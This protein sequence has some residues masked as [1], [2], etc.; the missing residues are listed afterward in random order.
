MG[1]IKD[2]GIGDLNLFVNGAV[3]RSHPNDNLFSIDTPSG[4]VPVAGLLYDAPNFG[5]V[6][7]GHTGTALYL[8]TRYDITSTG[9]KIGL[10]YNYGSK[11]W[12]AFTPASDDMWTSKL[13]AHGN[14]YEA[15]VIQEIK[16]KPISKV[17]QGLLQAG[18]SVLRF[19]LHRKQQ[20]GGSAEK[21]VGFEQPNERP[22]VCTS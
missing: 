22:D 21:H 3:S 20:L 18:V 7:E 4:P 8:G 12:V 9:T 11:Y 19:Q 1:K 2:I 10:E 5:G 13:G 14:V 15:Y 17:R 16:S 6:K